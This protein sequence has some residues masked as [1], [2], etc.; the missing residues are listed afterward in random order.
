[1]KK[2]LGI[3]VSLILLPSAAFAS[4]TVDGARQQADQVF[5]NLR[6][7]SDNCY[8]GNQGSQSPQVQAITNNAKKGANLAYYTSFNKKSG[9]A[10]WQKDGLLNLSEDILLSSPEHCDYLREIVELYDLGLTPQ[11][12]NGDKV[13]SFAYAAT[14][15]YRELSLGNVNQPYP[16]PNP[17]PYIE[18]MAFEDNGYYTSVVN[19]KYPSDTQVYAR[20]Q[21]TFIK[22]APKWAGNMAQVVVKPEFD[23]AEQ[24]FYALLLRAIT[25]GQETKVTKA[26]V[27]DMF[28]IAF[29]VRGIETPASNDDNI[30]IE[31]LG[32][33]PSVFWM[34]N[35]EEVFLATK[36]HNSLK[37]LQAKADKVINDIIVKY[38]P[39][40]D[41]EQFV[42]QALNL[43]Q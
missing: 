8:Y 42:L 17:N 35:A 16:G 21:K 43:P 41:Y 29:Y 38:T 7:F 2:M 11:S 39:G 10:T 26:L 34:K 4:L 18:D 13:S 36:Q 31:K 20:A 5:H 37:K 3:A 25:S 6:S 22:Q 28:A 19:D 33:Q 40:S 15:A 1:M 9:V 14:F 23:E 32:N 12:Y 27:D 24:N 30:I